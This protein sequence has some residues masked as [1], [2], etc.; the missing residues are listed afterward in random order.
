MRAFA[1]LA[2]ASTVLSITMHARADEGASPREIAE[3]RSEIGA[4]LGQMR[5]S[6]LRVRDQLRLTR[7]RGTRVQITCVDEALSRS[8]VALRRA[9]DLGDET[10]AA[11]ARND[12]DAAHLARRQLGELR[13]AQRVAGVDA[14][15][16]TPR[17]SP[18]V[19]LTVAQST[20][21]KVDVDPNIAPVSVATQ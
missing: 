18:Q 9:R 7:K 10:L 4:T 20:T 8:D 6:S 14:A 5:A 12:L 15:K 16:C 19:Q 1:A 17:P 13:E 3:A 2:V 21:V 11:Y